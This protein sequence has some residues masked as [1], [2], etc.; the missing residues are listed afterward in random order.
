MD[1]KFYPWFSYS[2][3]AELGFQAA[4]TERCYMPIP[5]KVTFKRELIGFNPFNVWQE[6][7]KHG[8]DDIDG[9]ECYVLAARDQEDNHSLFIEGPEDET[10]YAY[11]AFM[12]GIELVF[13]A[14]KFLYVME[15]ASKN[16]KLMFFRNAKIPSILEAN[17][18]LALVDASLCLS[19]KDRNRAWTWMQ[20]LVKGKRI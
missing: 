8:P 13:E 16:N 5:L 14:E 6:S 4:M 3:R 15:N 17:K 2:K 10:C 18:F 9:T 11:D 7:M 19:I 20:Q 1:A 12:G